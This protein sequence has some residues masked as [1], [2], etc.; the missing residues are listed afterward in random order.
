MGFFYGAAFVKQHWRPIANL[1]VSLVYL[2]SS[3]F[4]KNTA[5]D[6]ANPHCPVLVVRDFSIRMC[7]SSSGVESI[8][9]FTLLFFLVFI[10]NWKEIDKKKALVF[11]F[12]GLAGR[13]SLYG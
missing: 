8:A 10:T 12:I 5:V 4:F 11:Y 1:V 3:L 7:A 13:G 2:I 6:I 9:Y